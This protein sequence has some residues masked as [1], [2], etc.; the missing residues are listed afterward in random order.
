MAAT[1]DRRPLKPNAD[2]PL[3][4]HRNGQFCKKIRGKIEY[5]G[6]NPDEA[7]TEYLRVEDHLQAGQ[8][9]PAFEDPDAVTV[10]V[11]V[12]RYLVWC[13]NRRDKL[14]RTGESGITP[15]TYQDYL[16][17][18]VTIRNS[19]GETTS[20]DRLTSETFAKRATMI[21]THDEVN[22]DEVNTI[23]SLTPTRMA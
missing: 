15:V 9:R 11:L 6:A 16:D 8:P 14:V 22:T 1:T 20:V 3:T 17:V 10:A 12:N 4:P 23:M 18:G 2:F 19:L 13:R 7:L 5:F 21:F